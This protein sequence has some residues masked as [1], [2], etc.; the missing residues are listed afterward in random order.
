M[1]MIV[2]GAFD[3]HVMVSCAVMIGTI[4]RVFMDVVNG[5]PETFA[6]RPAPCRRR[7]GK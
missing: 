4:S 5:M 2:G 1:R 6:A 7:S 3:D